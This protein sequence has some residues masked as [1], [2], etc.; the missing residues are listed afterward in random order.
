MTPADT[1]RVLAKA[2]AYD[3]R[4]VGHADVLAWHEA[5][6]DLDPTDAL[7]AVTR[8]YR[9]NTDRLMPAHIRRNVTTIRAERR[10]AQHSEPLAL[11]SRFEDDPDRAERIARGLAQVRDVIGPVLDEL[12]ARRARRTA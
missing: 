6:G 7:T 3:Q 11:P 10:T 4:T 2:A 12:A 5:L 9:D 1:A 8:H